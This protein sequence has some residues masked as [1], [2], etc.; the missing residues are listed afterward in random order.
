MLDRIVTRREWTFFILMC[1][2]VFLVG[3][4]TRIPQMTLDSIS[5]DAIPVAYGFGRTNRATISISDADWAK[6]ERTF[7]PAPQTPQE[8]R[9]RLRQS[10]AMMERIAGEQTPICHDVGK[11]V[12]P[13]AG[14]GQCDCI[15]ESTNTTVYLHLFRQSHFLHWHD[16]L[17]PTF[18]APLIFDSHNTAQIRDRSTG[19]CYAVDSW[20]LDSGEPP[21]IQEIRS[22]KRKDP[23]PPEENPPMDSD[24]SAP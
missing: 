24:D 17:E 18:R 11:N 7:K 3:C 9:H 22:W 6:L 21:Y 15:D 16:V 10:V 1:G 13:A 12:R 19:M 23:F 8:E 14:I 2:V 4:G 5:R 20:F